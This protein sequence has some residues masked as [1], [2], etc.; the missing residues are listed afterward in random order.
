MLN[1][2]RTNEWLFPMGSSLQAENDAALS[3]D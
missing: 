1:A 3:Q 2:P